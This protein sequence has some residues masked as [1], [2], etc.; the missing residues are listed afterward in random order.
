MTY[1]SPR[2]VQVSVSLPLDLLN[3]V[4]REATHRGLSRS[5]V[6]TELLRRALGRRSR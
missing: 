3:Q 1:R 2:A 4:D 6:L 5:R